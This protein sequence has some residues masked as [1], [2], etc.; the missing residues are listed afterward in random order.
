MKQLGI[1]LAVASLAGMLVSARQ[2]G[3][4]ADELIRLQRSAIAAEVKKDRAALE[5]MYA[6]DYSYIHSNGV[7]SSKTE[8]LASSVS[9]DINWT[10]SAFDDAKARLYGDAAIVTGSETLMGTA[11]GYV[12]GARRITDIWVKRNGEWKTVG[13]ASTI[14]SKDGASTANVSTVKELKART[15]AGKT[16]DERAVLQADTAYAATDTDATDAKSRTMETKDY[17]FVSRAG[18]VA[19]PSDSPGPQHKSNVVAY[20][21]VRAYGTLAVVHG[22]LVWAD[23]KN[24]SP[25]VLRFMRVWVKDG[26]AWKLAAEQRTPIAAAARPKT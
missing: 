16:A 14:V 25:G 19:A 24:F 22:S 2:S 1:G 23:V 4:P 8:D 13:G 6:A 10:S 9:P 11:K 17:S 12:P 26:A 21:S 20:D 3:S 5:K 7:V 18:A 15:I